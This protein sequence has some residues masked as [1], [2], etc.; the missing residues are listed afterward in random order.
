MPRPTDLGCGRP[1]R[2][3]CRKTGG[4]PVP[5]G[6]RRHS[7]SQH[8]PAPPARRLR[9]KSIPHGPD[10]EKPGGRSLVAGPD[11][12]FYFAGFLVQSAPKGGGADSGW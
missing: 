3:A 10:A 8:T 6:L 2:V 11:E 4:T 1:A 5:P 12:A 9:Q 7:Y